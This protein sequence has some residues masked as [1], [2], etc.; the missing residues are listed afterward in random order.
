MATG[1]MT[2]I[3]FLGGLLKGLTQGDI[4]R[5]ELDLKTR[6]TAVQEGWLNRALEFMPYD[7]QAKE[8]ANKQMQY[9]NAV[10]QQLTPEQQA[11]LRILQWGVPEGLTGAVY[12]TGGQGVA[13]SL[14]WLNKAFNIGIPPVDNFTGLPSNQEMKAQ[15]ELLK[16]QEKRKTEKLKAQE[17]MNLKKYE[18]RMKAYLEK[19]KADLKSQYNTGKSKNNWIEKSLKD[20][21]AK[22]MAKA[23]DNPEIASVYERAYQ[24]ALDLA[25][26]P[27]YDDKKRV[28]YYKK[29]KSVL[30]KAD[31]NPSE[32]QA[33]I[34]KFYGREVKQQP[35]TNP[36][37]AF[38]NNY[39]LGVK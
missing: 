1:S 29:L 13:S 10:M 22:A 24:F 19:L 7:I 26:N 12:K 9:Q 30:T 3:G 28:Q 8:L 18:M 32:I 14:D 5:K 34:D 4:T 17:K 21:I 2:G 31:A 23:K 36:F 35:Q 39:G 11:R 16:E 33:I 27:E 38:F 37:D 20:P 6:N 25:N 15:T